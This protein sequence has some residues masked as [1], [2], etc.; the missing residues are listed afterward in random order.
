[1]LYLTLFL[2]VFFFTLS[3]SGGVW[4]SLPNLSTKV[5]SLFFLLYYTIFG[6]VRLPWNNTKSIDTKKLDA[7]WSVY[8]QNKMWSWISNWRIRKSHLHKCKNGSSILFVVNM[9]SMT[10]FSNDVFS[11][12]FK[13]ISSNR[14][15]LLI[16]EYFCFK[17]LQSIYLNLFKLLGVT[18]DREF[19]TLRPYDDMLFKWVLLLLVSLL[20]QCSPKQIFKHRISWKC[21]CLCL[22]RNILSQKKASHLKKLTEVKQDWGNSPKRNNTTFY[23]W[24]K[25]THVVVSNFIL[26]F[27]S[28]S[29]KIVKSVIPNH[30]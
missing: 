1:M 29:L 27:N 26:M 4:C 11:S 9:N 14:S 6:Y 7:T 19:V 13:Y 23:S 12:R 16:L 18:K 20:L 2:F 25:R 5:S 30:F 17:I 22:K 24:S 10:A 3:F 15:I 8:T 21:P 28:W